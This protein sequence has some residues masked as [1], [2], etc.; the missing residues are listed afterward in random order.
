VISFRAALYHLC[1]LYLI[2]YSSNSV[3][4]VHMSRMSCDCVLHRKC[5]VIV[6]SNYYKHLHAS[7]D[8]SAKSTA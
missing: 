7:R 5:T 6:Y 4:H 8:V 3:L 2:P 1:V